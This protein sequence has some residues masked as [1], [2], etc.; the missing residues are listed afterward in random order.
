MCGIA[1]YYASKKMD[2]Q[3][4]I[5]TLYHRG[6]DANGIFET[7][8]GDKLLGL[9]H[10]RLSIIDLSEQNNQPFFSDD[11]KIAISFNGEIYN[12]NE[13]KQS[14]LKNE[15]F[16]TNGDTEVILKMYQK[17]GVNCL[18]YFNGAF[19]IA[20]VDLISN[21]LF[22]IRDR[23]GIKPLYI[24]NNNEALIFSSEIKTILASGIKAEL[25]KD[26]LSTFFAFKYMPQNTTLFKGIEKLAPGTY[27]EIDLKS[28]AIATH[29]YW[30]PSSI[31]YFQKMDYKEAQ[32]E[33]YDL[34]ESAVAFRT[35]ADVPLGNFLSGGIDSS[36]IAYYLKDKIDIT[37]Y[38]ASKNTEDLKTE[39]TT[40]DFDYAEHL[41]NDWKLK[42]LPI[43]IGNEELNDEL[44]NKTLWYGDDL[45]ADGS[46][47]PSYLITQKAKETSK[48]V[49]SGMGADELFFGYAAHQLIILDNYFDKF[50]FQTIFSSLL[51]NLNQGKG[52]LKAFKRYLFKIGKYHFLPNYKYGIYGIVGDFDTSFKILE[53]PDK[54]QVL[55]FIKPY[56]ENE[57]DNFK[58]FTNFEMDNF[59]QKN[60]NYFDRMTMANGVEGRVPFLDHRVVEFAYNLPNNFKINKKAQTK[61]IL[62]DTYKNKLPNYILNRRKA[63]FGMPLRS[64]LLNKQ[65]V[66]SL[67]NLPYLLDLNL[68]FNEKA[69]LEILDEHIQGKQDNSA[70]LYA[71]VS[72][73]HWH[74]QFFNS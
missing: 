26:L 5:A 7:Q 22:I 48:V 27:L 60:I 52:Y 44:I 41:A 20:I 2:L 66:L 65:K 59:L 31:D 47:I 39:N 3:A 19:A 37:H 57:K 42:L 16:K 17:F 4:M 55:N 21:R 56:F 34:M 63:G 40:S 74:K 67:M 36:I 50:P 24:Y 61:L 14:Y 23:I 45:I 38:C 68:G 51:S 12:F 35:I 69:I 73:N 46:Q 71:V 43:A 58:A 6:P 54:E 30:K 8:I 49:L 15:Q 25:N 64:L 1:G 9:G 10:S 11:K 32:D 28:Q 13:L 70:L 29:T 72:F 62:K 18:K 33:L 53:K